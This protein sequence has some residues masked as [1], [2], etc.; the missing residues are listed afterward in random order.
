VREIISGLRPPLLNY[1]LEA[2]LRGLIDD[3]ASQA[4]IETNIETQIPP[5][6]ARYPGEVELHLYRII[7]QACLNAVKHSQASQIIIKG[8]LTQ[9]AVSLVVEDNGVGLDSHQV[10]NLEWLLANKHFG[11]A[12]MLERASLIG[13]HLSLNSAPGEGMQVKVTWQPSL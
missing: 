7:Q 5:S 6:S 1:A 12:N 13:A 11:L 8:E 2:A 4:A 10:M 9:E 3:V